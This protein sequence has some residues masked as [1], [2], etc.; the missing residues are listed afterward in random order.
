MGSP[1]ETFANFTSDNRSIFRGLYTNV[2]GNS[3]SYIYYGYAEELSAFWKDYVFPNTN[4]DVLKEESDFV[5]TNHFLESGKDAFSFVGRMVLS[6]PLA[7]EG[8]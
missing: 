5:S 7:G 6:F 2:V 8:S 1:T 3:A 4:G